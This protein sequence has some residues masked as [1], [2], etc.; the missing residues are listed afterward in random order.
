MKGTGIVGIVRGLRAERE[1]ALGLLP[2][3]LHHYLEQRVVVTA[4]YPETDYVQLMNALLRVYKRQ[5]WESAGAMAAR[6]ALQGVY[7]NIVVAGQVEQTA[8]R[9]RVNWRNY[10]DTG[11][12]TVALRP[13][14]VQVTVTDYCLVSSDVCLLNQGYFAT[15]LELAGAEVT[16]RRKLRCRAAGDS[17][18]V[19][20]YA[21]RDSLG[22][23]ARPT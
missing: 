1:A 4:W 21:W 5:T 7:R 9:M 15:I 16:A 3:P 2:A 14:L 18:C 20:E 23:S 19:W 13:G 17:L 6:E 11:D 22:P 8:Q 12:L 10:H